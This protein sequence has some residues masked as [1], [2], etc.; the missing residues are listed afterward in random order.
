MKRFLHVM[1]LLLLGFL[2]SCQGSESGDG[3]GEGNYDVAATYVGSNAELIAD[4]QATHEML[5]ETIQ[6]ATPE[7]WTFRENEDRWNTAEVVEHIVIAENMFY[8][9]LTG[10]VL[11]GDASD[12]IEED[13]TEVDAGI[14]MFIRDRST[15]FDAPEPAQPQGIYATPE[16]A[17][18]AFETAR[19]NTVE[20]L[21]NTDLNL[22]AYSASIPGSDAPPMDGHQW[23]IFLSGHSARHTAQIEQIKA[24]SDY[25]VG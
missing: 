19:S 16:E 15:T 6:Y 25:P 20:F 2:V 23:F 7:Q 10:V 17:M 1:P 9:M 24:D 13:L 14:A 8:A 12:I 5:I 11:V 4:L 21:T 18:E 3:A 22:R